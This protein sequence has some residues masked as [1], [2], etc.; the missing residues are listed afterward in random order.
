MPAENRSKKRIPYS[1][2]F[3]LRFSLQFVFFFRFY[4]VSFSVTLCMFLCVSLSLW[5]CILLIVSRR[6][7]IGIECAPWNWMHTIGL[8]CVY[9]NIMYCNTFG[10]SLH[11][12]FLVSPYCTFPP[13]HTWT[14]TQRERW[15]YV[16][17]NISIFRRWLFQFSFISLLVV[18]V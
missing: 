10:C 14:H 3:Y 18:R 17:V 15:I 12:I 1:I 4:L 11:L 8:F 9:I 6:M 16:Y 13:S 5:H 2:S 7:K